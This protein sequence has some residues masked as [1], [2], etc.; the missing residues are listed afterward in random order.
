[1]KRNFVFLLLLFIG[2]VFGQNTPETYPTDPASVE[3]TSVPKGEIIKFSFENSKIFPGTTR[4]VSIYIPAQYDGQK[5]AC[6]Y[7]NQDGIQ[8]K[9]P[10]VFDNLIHQNEMPITIGVFITP[11][12]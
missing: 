11:G 8:W 4:E 2:K 3:K 7:V 6:V 5:P 12:Q 1:M 10:T 9:A